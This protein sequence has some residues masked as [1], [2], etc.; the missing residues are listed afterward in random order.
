MNNPKSSEINALGLKFWWFDVKQ[1][2]SDCEVGISWAILSFLDLW[3]KMALSIL[4]K[5]QIMNN[6]DVSCLMYTNPFMNFMFGHPFLETLVDILK[7]FQIE[8]CCGAP[9]CPVR[10]WEVPYTTLHCV[11]RC[12]DVPTIKGTLKMK[13]TSKWKMRSLS[14]KGW[15]GLCRWVCKSTFW[16]W[17][18]DHHFG[19]QDQ[20]EVWFTH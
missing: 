19:D 11:C 12:F 18:M 4:S 8:A 3:S 20:H 17:I 9:L 2:T 14:W 1:V 6:Y 10:S 13:L 15:R 5:V 16:S 7:T